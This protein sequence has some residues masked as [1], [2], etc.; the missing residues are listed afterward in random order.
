M[1]V[2]LESHGC[3]GK[4]KMARVTAKKLEDTRKIY[5]LQRSSKP[6][7]HLLVR[8]RWLYKVCF[9]RGTVCRCDG[10]DRQD[11]A[12]WCRVWQHLSCLGL[13][14]VLLCIW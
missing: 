8:T 1:A 4:L 13:G 14:A 6:T 10:N 9:Q 11:V 7:V 2:G 3:H 5:V 12:D